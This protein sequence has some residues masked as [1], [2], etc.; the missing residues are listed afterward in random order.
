MIK[1]L[2]E[3]LKHLSNEK[4]HIF[5]KNKI[6]IMFIVDTCQIYILEEIDADIIN[7]A[8]VCK[9]ISEISI[10][11][12]I[13]FNQVLN[14]INSIITKLKEDTL[15]IETC[16]RLSLNSYYL[17]FIDYCNMNCS[18]CYI[19]KNSTNSAISFETAIRSA[20]I[21]T[22][23]GA[24]G[25]G[26]HG[27]EHLLEFDLLKKFI[28]ETRKRNIPLEI[29]LSLNGTLV[30]Q[31]IASFFREN[32]I[33]VSVGIDGTKETHDK[34]RRYTNNTSSYNDVIK[35]AKILNENGILAAIEVTMSRR[36]NFKF[37][38]MVDSLSGF[39]VPILL[40]RVNSTKNNNCNDDA[41][42]GKDLKQYLEDDFLI[43]ADNC[44]TYGKSNLINI[45]K[46]LRYK[47]EYICSYILDSVSVD[48]DGEVYVSPKD[49]IKANSIGNIHDDN[50]IDYF[51]KNRLD[52]MKKYNKGICKKYW[53]SNLMENCIDSLMPCTENIAKN[54]YEL[55][56]SD[57]WSDYFENIIYERVT[58][59]E[60]KLIELFN[61]WDNTGF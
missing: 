59:S 36:H 51:E 23:L 56:D 45:S 34:T 33:V 50:F 8:K 44:I 17:K 6:W 53:F 1:H 5:S 38:E 15:E 20:E 2:E 52:K 9:S 40:A 13:D 39:D 24:S 27:G 61:N 19:P 16:D 42:F 11:L 21:M 14:R 48:M 31:E 25:V 46:P 10:S 54:S 4:F 37:T 60:N 3:E 29:G 28:V 12:N 18:Y 32:N 49:H 41:F 35:G 55:I 57:V 43:S 7:A 22:F 58:M 30:N 26:I 47:N